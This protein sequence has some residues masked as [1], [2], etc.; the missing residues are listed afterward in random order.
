[1]TGKIGSQNQSIGALTAWRQNTQKKI[2]YI[3]ANPKHDLL[4]GK[5]EKKRDRT[6]EEEKEIHP[7]S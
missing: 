2:I 5:E 6:P 7:H 1:L 4:V 3:L